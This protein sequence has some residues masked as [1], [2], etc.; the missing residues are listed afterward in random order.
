MHDVGAGAVALLSE[1]VA[2]DSVNPGL[3]PGAAGES[4]MVEHLRTRLE[5]SGFITTVVPAPGHPARP[6][7]RLSSST[8]IWTPWVLPGWWIRSPRTSRVTAC[9]AGV[10]RT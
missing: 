6:S 9:T 3:V 10:R 8:R 5:G 4:G 2:I 1:L 7:G